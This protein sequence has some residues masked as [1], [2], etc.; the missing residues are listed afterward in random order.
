MLS[1]SSIVNDDGICKHEEFVRNF[2]NGIRGT[3]CGT[4]AYADVEIP[5]HADV[6]EQRDFQRANFC[7][8]F[9]GP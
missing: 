6:V 7:I 2:T 3:D 5:L 8:F 4:R 9:H 1:R